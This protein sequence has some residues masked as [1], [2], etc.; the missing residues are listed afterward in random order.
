MH[1]KFWLESL[2]GKLVKPGHRGQDNIKMDHRE[3]VEELWSRFVWLRRE[4]SGLH[5]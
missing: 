1:A 2:K 5:V 4:T 3:Y